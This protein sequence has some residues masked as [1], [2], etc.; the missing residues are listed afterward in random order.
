[1]DDYKIKKAESQKGGWVDGQLSG[2]YMYMLR[3]THT[4]IV[5]Q[6]D[7]QVVRYVDDEIWLDGWM[8]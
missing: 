4:Q 6:L 5:E 3:L 2:K 7:G 1:M 8:L